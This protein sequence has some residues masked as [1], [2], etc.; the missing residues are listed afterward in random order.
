MH[1][2]LEQLQGNQV[3]RESMNMSKFTQL[4]KDQ[5]SVLKDKKSL[6]ARIKELLSEIE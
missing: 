3:Q 5:K 4:K 1:E 2:Q 6:E